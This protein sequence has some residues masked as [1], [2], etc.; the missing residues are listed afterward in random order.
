MTK[1]SESESQSRTVSCRSLSAM[2]P[3]P[4]AHPL[5]GSYITHHH[6]LQSTSY[7][8]SELSKPCPKTLPIMPGIQKPHPRTPVSHN[9]VRRREVPWKR[10]PWSAPHSI[11][12]VVPLRLSFGPSFV[13]YRLFVVSVWNY[14]PC[15]IRYIGIFR[16]PAEP[17]GRC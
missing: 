3:L 1:T 4:L 15:K 8:V 10:R 11:T 2:K 7:S 6:V 13:T 9:D 17:F 5:S 16:Y 14:R 12:R